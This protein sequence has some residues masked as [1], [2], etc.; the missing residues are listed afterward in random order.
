MLNQKG[1]LALDAVCCQLEAEPASY[2]QG[3]WG[4]DDKPSCDTPGC[5]AGHIV[6]TIKSANARYKRRIAELK[7]T[8]TKTDHENA[9]QDAATEALGL[10]ETP[11]LFEPE[12]PCQWIEKA[13]GTTEHWI[14]PDIEPSADDAIMVLQ[15]VMDGKL[16][17]ALEPSEMLTRE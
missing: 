10:K 13:G 15:T 6:A 1:L 14:L 11:R 7:G 8:A 3:E 17:E 4:A 16:D 12:W 9:I 2:E 5:V